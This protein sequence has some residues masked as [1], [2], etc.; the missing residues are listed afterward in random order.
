ML[1]SGFKAIK[2][3]HPPV[4]IFENYRVVKEGRCWLA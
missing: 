4:A 1:R 2:L 3:V